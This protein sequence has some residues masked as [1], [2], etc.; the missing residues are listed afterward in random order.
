MNHLA[1]CFLS[2]AD[3]DLLLGNFIGDFVKG[4]DWQQYPPAVQQ[5]I[6][7]HRTIDS[8]TDSHPMTDRSVARI[9]PFAGRYSPPFTDILYD[10][11]LALNWE[12]YTDVSFDIFA[13]Q[14]YRQ[15]ENRA[16][17]MPPV[18][19]ERLPK[20]IAGQFLHGYTLREGLEWVLDR[21]S[22]RLAGHFDAKALGSFFFDEIDAFSEDFNAFFPDL[23]DV[24]RNKVHP[25]K[26]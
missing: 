3:E 15:L 24:C 25:S 16:A 14:T 19:Q 9:R 17:E 1:H 23:L 12:K 26:R 2:F 8:Y 6:L 20:M 5:G 4:N 22:M 18:L 11:L 21:F 13:A 7:L 10:H